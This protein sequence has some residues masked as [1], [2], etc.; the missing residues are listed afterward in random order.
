VTKSGLPIK[1]EPLA[2]LLD[3]R[4]TNNDPTNQWIFLRGLEKLSNAADGESS[5][6]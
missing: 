3:H 4:E 6:S 1:D 2:Y 5:I